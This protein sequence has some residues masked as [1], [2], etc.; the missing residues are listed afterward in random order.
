MAKIRTLKEEMLAGGDSQEHVYPRT[1]TKAV[2]SI[3]NTTLQ[4]NLDDIKTG[5]YLGNKTIKERHLGDQNVTTQKIKDSAITTEKL[6]DKSITN[7]KLADN[8]IASTKLKPELRNTIISTYDKTIELDNK[9]ANI[10]DVGN[11]IERL[12]NKI[13]ERIL[14]EGDVTN[15]PDD[16]DLTSV[17][18]IDGR[19]VMKLNDRTYEPS[20]FSGKGYKIL[21]KNIKKLD[22][23]TVDIVVSSAPTSSGDIS[24]T[25][26]DKVT[27]INLDSTTDTTTAI[28]ATKIAA[29][30]KTY[31][32]DYDVSVSSNRITLTRH[33]GSSVSPSSINVGSTSAVISVKDSITENVRKNVLTQDMI[34]KPNTVYEIRYDFDLNEKTINIKEGCVLKFVGGRL[35]N[36]IL[37]CNNSKILQTQS[38]FKNIKFNGLVANEIC[39]SSFIETDIITGLQDM[40]NSCIYDINFIIDVSFTIDKTIYIKGARRVQYKFTKKLY[41]TIDDGSPCFV[42]EDIGTVIVDG[43]KISAKNL[44]SGKNNLNYIGI[45]AIKNVQISTFKNIDIRNSEIGLQFGK[46]DVKTSGYL[47]NVDNIIV[48]YSNI[49]IQIN[50]GLDGSWING[51]VFKVTDISDNNIGLDCQFGTGNTI[52]CT[53]TEIGRNNIGIKISGGGYNIFGYQWNEQPKDKCIYL[54][55][56]ITRFIGLTGINKVNSIYVEKNAVCI[57]DDVNELNIKRSC[58]NL[59]NLISNIEFKNLYD[60]KIYDSILNTEYIASDTLQFIERGEFKSSLLVN[61]K[62]EIVKHRPYDIPFK[63]IEDFSI[64]F[65]FNLNGDLSL[66][67]FQQSLFSFRFTQA[68]QPSGKFYMFIVRP[69]LYLN[70]EGKN[71]VSTIVQIRKYPENVLVEELELKGVFDKE[72]GVL[73][74]AISYDS[75]GGKIFDQYGNTKTLDIS[76]IY[77]FDEKLYSMQV[78]CEN[79]I[80]ENILVGL[81]SLSIYNKCLSCNELIDLIRNPVHKKPLNIGTTE[82]RPKGVN[83]GFIYKDNTINKLIIW[84]GT[85]WINMDGTALG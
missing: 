46:D 18:T 54:S 64:V 85:Q 36:G 16:E 39:A 10:A 15:L 58:V 56:G 34:N 29:A 74:A 71:S 6:K 27:T 47:I 26:N 17:S 8:T 57:F 80:D 65:K 53:N 4:D 12:E 33:N 67:V 66:K 51:C 79:I 5:E 55:G 82:Q 50:K 83:V 78:Y 35:K 61:K 81:E 30:L 31:L 32:D 38:C 59:T 7:S 42:F 20:N 24:I 44:P 63:S 3:D 68:Q 40:F 22:I 23:P 70:K 14:V 45:Q 19:E 9:K 76:S 84:D 60:N 69:F 25:V 28:V 2:Y 77:Q 37:A 73:S 52:L 13:G 1:V 41:T 43:L 75:K 11:A 72:R 21:R 49:G 48:Y 62:G